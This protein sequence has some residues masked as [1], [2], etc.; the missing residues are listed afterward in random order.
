[1]WPMRVG[2]LVET[3]C[4]HYTFPIIMHIIQ[5]NIS[6]IEEIYL[7]KNRREYIRDYSWAIPSELAIKTICKYAP[8]V[9]M[10]AGGGYW[11][12][13]ISQNGIPITALDDC[14]ESYQKR[15]IEAKKGTP[16]SLKNYSDHTLFLCWPPYSSSMASNSLE[17]FSGKNV[18]YIGEEEG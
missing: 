3:I 18:I 1:M 4:S 13:L 7:R 17:E 2:R 12:Y 15:W 5:P 8:I 10:G 16:D 9:E 6:D 11:A 14:S